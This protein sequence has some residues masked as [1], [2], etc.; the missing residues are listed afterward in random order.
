MLIDDAIVE[1]KLKTV[2]FPT[3]SALRRLST[4]AKY[5]M[6][7]RRAITDARPLN[8]HV[9]EHGAY[10]KLDDLRSYAENLL[11]I[12]GEKFCTRAVPR[13]EAVG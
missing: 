7:R 12:A 4:D 11:L 3:S 13:V 1:Y 2:L 5:R 8:S 10:A 9:P 6:G